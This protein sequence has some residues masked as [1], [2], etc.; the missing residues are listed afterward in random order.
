MIFICFSYIHNELA[1]QKCVF[2]FSRM[3]MMIFIDRFPLQRDS[4]AQ[5]LTYRLYGIA[6]EQAMQTGGQGR[7]IPIFTPF[8][9]HT[10]ATT[11]S[12]TRVSTLF[13]LYYQKGGY[14]SEEKSRMHW[15]LFIKLWFLVTA[16]F[17]I[18]NNC[19]IE[20]ELQVQHH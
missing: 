9:T 10:N 12:K 1:I 4:I 11:V 18:M 20:N 2:F 3:V 15:P 5:F 19:T 16:R 14:R 13:Q 6:V 7:T 17:F 8:H